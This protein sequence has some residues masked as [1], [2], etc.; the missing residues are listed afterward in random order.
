MILAIL[1][2]FLLTGGF[3]LKTSQYSNKGYYETEVITPVPGSAEESLQLETFAVKKCRSNTAINF[4]IDNSGSMQFGNKMQELKTALITFANEFPPS[5]AIALQ[6]YSETV[7]NRVDFSLFIDSKQKFI[8][9]VEDMD[10]MSATHSKD[11]FLAAQN[12]FNRGKTL[13][14]DY[15]FAL[16][17][18]SDGIP[19]TRVGNNTCGGG[20]C[21]GG[22]CT[23]TLSGGECRNGIMTGG[24]CTGGT[25][26]EYCM[27]HPILKNTCRCYDPT[28]DPTQIANVLK[29]ILGIR[30][31]TIAFTDDLADARLNNKL[32]TLMQSLASPGDYYLAPIETELTDIIDEVTNEICTQ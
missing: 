22:T 23:G 19:E 6:T 30:I 17:F 31:F 10:W 15:Q 29:N 12:S 18:I 25:S 27:E 28:Q 32:Q 24:T 21:G 2:G 11:A 16:I 26:T 20:T 4:L 3:Y 14:P 8:N 5:G 7:K 13:F 9:E 1:F